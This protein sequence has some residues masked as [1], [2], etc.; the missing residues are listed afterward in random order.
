MPKARKSRPRNTKAMAVAHVEARGD[1]PIPTI[2]KNL[3]I[4]DNATTYFCNVVNTMT[5]NEGVT[6]FRWFTRLPG[7]NLE[8]CRVVVPNELAEKLIDTLC[9]LSGHYPERPAEQAEVAKQK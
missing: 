1:E 3:P 7:G 9:R 8:Q 2:D 4:N 5:S 6:Y